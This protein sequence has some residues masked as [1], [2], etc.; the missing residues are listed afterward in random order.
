MP[1]TPTKEP[2]QLLHLEQVPVSPLSEDDYHTLNYP[3]HAWGQR[4]K[5]R[6]QRNHSK[7][8]ITSILDQE[9]EDAYHDSKPRTRHSHVQTRVNST[10]RTTYSSNHHD[11]SRAST[12]FQ[13]DSSHEDWNEDS[14]PKR[15]TIHRREAVPIDDE[16]DDDEYRPMKRDAQHGRRTSGLRPHGQRTIRES[17]RAQV[18]RVKV[19]PDSNSDSPVNTKR[20]FNNRRRL[21]PERTSGRT[22]VEI[23]SKTGV[24]RVECV[25][26][27]AWKKQQ[28][29][30]L[31]EDT[32]S[33]LQ[34]LPSLTKQHEDHSQQP[35][36]PT[37]E[38]AIK[39]VQRR[40]DTL[41]PTS[42]ASIQSRSQTLKAPKVLGIWWLEIKHSHGA[43]SRVQEGSLETPFVRYSTWWIETW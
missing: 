4:V 13:P 24:E 6:N 29:K 34:S 18:G 35:T 7:R 41:V 16:D 21:L 23:K 15:R 32:K 38:E 8:L 14:L 26:I 30:P 42:T 19:D 3:I 11:S 22:S 31:A 10:R 36:E 28:G 39:S 17:I 43:V 40:D 33:E 20:G 9:V 27:P 37:F 5:T 1:S 2:E 25:L 12:P